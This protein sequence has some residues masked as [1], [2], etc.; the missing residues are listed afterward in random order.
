M[1]T[2]PI[3]LCTACRLFSGMKLQHLH[4]YDEGIVNNYTLSTD[5]L[6]LF[7][8]GHQVSQKQRKELF[9]H[10]CEVSSYI[11]ITHFHVKGTVEAYLEIDLMSIIVLL[12]RLIPSNTHYE[13]MKFKPEV[14]TKLSKW[15]ELFLE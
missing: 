12:C 6:S 11:L 14:E 1:H 2:I 8:V 13:C 10:S 9:W 7:C 15:P 5:S 3:Y 4:S